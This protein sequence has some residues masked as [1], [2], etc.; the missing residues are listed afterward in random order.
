MKRVS[1]TFAEILQI[2]AFLLYLFGS[3]LTLIEHGA[4]LSLWIMTFAI[5]TSA[6]TTL[7]PWLGIHWLRL[8][9]R[10]CQAGAWLALLVQIASWGVFGYAMFLRLGRNLP[11][12]YSFTILL[13]LLWAS[14]LL[15]Y[16]YSR[17]ACHPNNVNDTL[18]INKENNSTLIKNSEER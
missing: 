18:D 7:L 5:A 14:W 3:S 2:F 12:F 4:E 13:T 8:E 17:H 1:I 11:R 15:I 6:A 9:K 16:C 10:G